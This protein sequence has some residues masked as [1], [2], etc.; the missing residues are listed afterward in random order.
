M[1]N[2]FDKS[3]PRQIIVLT[4]KAPT[5]IHLKLSSPA[6]NTYLSFEA[7]SKDPDHTAHIGAASLILDHAVCHRDL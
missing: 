5:K 7:N 1:P 3:S 2:I 6:V 4:L